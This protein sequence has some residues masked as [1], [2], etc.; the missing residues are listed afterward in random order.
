[1]R[2]VGVNFTLFNQGLIEN[3]KSNHTTAFLRLILTEDWHINILASILKEVFN[4]KLPYSNHFTCRF[5][6]IS[7]LYKKNV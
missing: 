2:V 5:I 6:L 3:L 7:H 4:F 1:M